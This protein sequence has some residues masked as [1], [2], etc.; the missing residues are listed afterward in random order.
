MIPHRLFR[1]AGRVKAVREAAEA[2]A[3]GAVVLF[4]GKRQG[5]PAQAAAF[6]CVRLLLPAGQAW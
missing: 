3:H 2:I 1:R 6:F 4:M 5:N